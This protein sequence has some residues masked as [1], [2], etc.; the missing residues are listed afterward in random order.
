MVMT[1]QYVTVNYLYLDNIKVS[2]TAWITKS[3]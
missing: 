3:A 1:L 2:K